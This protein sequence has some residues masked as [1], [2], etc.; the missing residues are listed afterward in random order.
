[1]RRISRQFWLVLAAGCV[2]V[3]ATAVLAYVLHRREVVPHHWAMVKRKVLYRSAQ[4]ADPLQWDFIR[5]RGIRTVVDL[6]FPVEDPAAFEQERQACA[7]AGI[8]LVSIPFTTPLPTD[9]QIRQFLLTMQ[10]GGPVLVHCQYGRSR[11]GLMVAAYRILLGNRTA[12]ATMSD[13]LRHGW[14]PEEGTGPEDVSHLLV[15]LEHDRQQWLEAIKSN[16]NRS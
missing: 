13:L 11:T 14:K 15:R 1:M 16:G 4:P 12:Q 8:K 9:E 6:R 2:L 7:A 5:R 3:P 10:Q